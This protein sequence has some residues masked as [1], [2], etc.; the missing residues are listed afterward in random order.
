MMSFDEFKKYLDYLEGRAAATAPS[1]SQKTTVSKAAWTKVQDRVE[2][3][4][5]ALDEAAD[6]AADARRDAK[7]ARKD[8]LADR[9]HISEETLRDLQLDASSLETRAGLMARRAH[10]EP[11][12]TAAEQEELKVLAKQLA[13]AEQNRKAA[14]AVTKAVTDIA[15]AIDSQA[16]QRELDRFLELFEAKQAKVLD[17]VP[18][19]TRTGVESAFKQLHDLLAA[20]PSGPADEAPEKAAKPVDEAIKRV[21]SALKTLETVRTHLGDPATLHDEDKVFYEEVDLLSEQLLQQRRRLAE[22][23]DA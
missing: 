3:C 1:P 6:A 2:A 4:A 16:T 23:D 13:A 7:H 12:L 20:T 22:S 10:P 19:A 14:A 17:G 11:A 5:K 15:R 8:D 21:D 18:A 9:F